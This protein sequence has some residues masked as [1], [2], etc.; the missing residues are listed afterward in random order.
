MLPLEEFDP[1]PDALINPS[2]IVRKENGAEYCVM[3][4]FREVVE[5]AAKAK[6]ARVVRRLIT[7][8]GTQPL[9][10]IEHR[11]KRLAFFLAGV[12]A[13]LAA[14]LFEETI[15]MGYTK[16][17]ACGSAGVLR[18][19]I[20]SGKIVVVEA[21]LRDEGTSFHYAPS[22]REIAAQPQVNAAMIEALEMAGLPYLSGKTWTTDAF[23]RETRARIARRA[24]EGCLTV[25]MEAAAFLA[26]AAF[27]KVKF[28]QFLY[29]GDDV[30]GPAW[31]KRGWRSK[32][33]V[34][35]R[36]F[37]LA[38]EACLLL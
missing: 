27:R 4:Y 25:D 38:A 2:D 10:E 33:S 23:F 1:D 18:P 37:W 29:A 11:G 6:K 16:F 8:I 24:A 35:E 17:V 34:R 19:D 21:A 5:K 28:G 32:K 9:Y 20:E 36:L 30:S 26:V 22:A 13:P 14:A 12:G 15:A 31:D 7:E 3:T